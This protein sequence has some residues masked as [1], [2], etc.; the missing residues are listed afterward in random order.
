MATTDSAQYER[1]ELYYSAEADLILLV[2]TFRYVQF[3]TSDLQVPTQTGNADIRYGVSEADL[4][5]ESP[6][7]RQKLEAGRL[8]DQSLGKSDQNP[9][10]LEVGQEDLEALL[11]FRTG[12]AC[13]PL[14]SML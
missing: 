6:I 8:T 11:G 4:C 5:R 12:R 10:P 3:V 14:V 7:L 1:S 2:G 9:L 13:V